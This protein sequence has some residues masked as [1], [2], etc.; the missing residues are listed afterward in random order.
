MIESPAERGI[1]HSLYEVSVLSGSGA[2]IIAVKINNGCSNSF[3]SHCQLLT[4]SLQLDQELL[5]AC[6][7]TSL[8][9]EE[10]FPLLDY[11]P[12]VDW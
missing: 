8:L 6:V 2:C 3:S 1:Q 9:I 4:F 5:G 7:K 11:E 10:T 12:F